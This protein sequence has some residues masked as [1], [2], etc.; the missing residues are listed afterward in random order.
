[1]EC[2]YGYGDI[3]KKFL[4]IK[5]PKFFYIKI[6]QYKNKLKT[7]PSNH[8]RIASRE[9]ENIHFKEIQYRLVEFN[10]YKRKE[11]RYKM[12]FV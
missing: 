2:L 6:C 11:T 3:H 5:N 12:L 4:K 1:M 8:L 10:I 9:K 7:K